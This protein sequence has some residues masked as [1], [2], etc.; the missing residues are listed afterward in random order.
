MQVYVA[1]CGKAGI[2]GY[3][4]PFVPPRTA[5][6][7]KTFRWGSGLMQ[8]GEGLASCNRLHGGRFMRSHKNP[9]AA[10]GGWGF[11][12]CRAAGSGVEVL[13]G[14]ATDVAGGSGVA[15]AEAEAFH[16]VDVYLDETVRF[17]SRRRLGEV[18]V[19]G[20]VGRVAVCGWCWLRRPM[21]IM[22]A[23]WVSR[24][25]GERRFMPGMVVALSP[26]TRAV[27]ASPAVFGPWWK[28]ARS[29]RRRG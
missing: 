22:S 6:G 21:R 18:G 4:C 12:C 20:G 26:P 17:L 1:E 16:D 25:S 19:V 13:G 9:H 3:R 7:K 24:A 2:Y 15:G 8:A 28:T 23:S 11:L 14:G 5:H 10:G 27:R 29:G